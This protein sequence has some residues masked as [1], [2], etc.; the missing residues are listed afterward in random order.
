[1]QY[2]K[3]QLQNQ[4]FLSTKDFRNMTLEELKQFIESK[5]PNKEMN[6]KIMFQDVQIIDDHSL[7]LV[8]QATDQQQVVKLNCI[9]ETIDQGVLC[10]VC[11][12]NILGDRYKCFICKDKNLC[13]KCY[14][15]HANVHPLILITKPELMQLVEPQKQN[16]GQALS[17]LKCSLWKPVEKIQE[18]K[19]TYDNKKKQEQSDKQ[20]K[21]NDRI[22]L[23]ME[24]FQGDHQQYALFVDKT[25]ELDQQE[26]IET[27]SEQFG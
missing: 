24:I 11:M 23:M 14:R 21:I 19:Q 22:L 25:I 20:K 9:K 17:F 26:F 12:S 2:L 7:H 15:Q 1:M 13:Q 3:V 16:I 5:L 8:K 27:A 18:I 4:T 10:S 6:Y